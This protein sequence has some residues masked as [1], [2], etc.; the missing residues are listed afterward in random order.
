MIAAREGNRAWLPGLARHAGFYIDGQR[1]V[2]LAQGCCKR[3]AFKPRRFLA[4]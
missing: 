1:I 3:N 2:Q 4:G